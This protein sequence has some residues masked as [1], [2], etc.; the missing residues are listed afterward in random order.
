MPSQVYF[1][2]YSFV[3]HSVMS[4]SFATPWTIAHQAPLSLGF[5]RQEYWSG[6]LF[7]S[8]GDLP[9]T[10]TEPGSPALQAV[11]LPS[12]LLYSFKHPL[13]CAFTAYPQTSNV[14]YCSRVTYIARFQGF[15]APPSVCSIRPTPIWSTLSVS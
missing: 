7:P 6:L 9:T 10:G 15:P 14:F 1:L 3:S 13:K 5:P 8:P 4:D 2:L 11:S 12:G